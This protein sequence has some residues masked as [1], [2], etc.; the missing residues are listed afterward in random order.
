MVG[1]LYIASF[2]WR[3]PKVIIEN[4]DELITKLSSILPRAL[5]EERVDRL[6]QITKEQCP[7]QHIDF[8]IFLIAISCIICSAVFTFIARSLNISMWF[9]LL[10]LLVPTALSFWT[11]KRRNKIYTKI[12]KFEKLLKKT[13]NEFTKNDCSHF[14]VWTFERVQL[15]KTPCKSIRLCFMVRITQLDPEI[16]LR[17]DGGSNNEELPT[18]HAAVQSTSFLLPPPAYID[19]NLPPPAVISLH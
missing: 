2:K 17:E 13:L 3:P 18:Y 7:S 10:L 14:I 1:H 5:A 11:S 8:Y 9:P 12:R 16:G 19:V 4:E 6:K 15:D